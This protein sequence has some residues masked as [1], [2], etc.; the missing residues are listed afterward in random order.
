MEFSLFEFIQEGVYSWIGYDSQI[1]F[2]RTGGQ[3]IIHASGESCIEEL[4][5][6]VEN[7][8]ISQG[9]LIYALHT[10]DKNQDI[11]FVR[12]SDENQDVRRLG[13][14]LMHNIGLL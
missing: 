9:E 10:H 1:T 12:E 8:H 6:I 14:W 4:L 3:C 11:F 5:F 7:K 13:T 2:W